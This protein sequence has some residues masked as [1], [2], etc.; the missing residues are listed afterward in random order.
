MMETEVMTDDGGG[1]LFME[2]RLGEE[3]N[4]ELF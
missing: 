4:G 1:K 2:E 3:N